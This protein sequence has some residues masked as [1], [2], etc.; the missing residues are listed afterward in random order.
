MGT[1]PFSYKVKRSN[2]RTVGIRIDKEGSVTVRAPKNVSSDDI[3]KF[4]LEKKGW[5]L[6]KVKLMRKRSSE[7][8]ERTFNQGDKLPYLGDV[9]KISVTDNE[10]LIEKYKLSRLNP[11]TLEDDFYVLKGDFDRKDAFIK[12]YKDEAREIFNSRIKELAEDYN[13]KYKKVKLSNAKTRWGSCSSKGNLNINW[14]IIFAPFE[15]VNYLLAHEVAH[16]KHHNHSK[17][18]WSLVEKYDSNYKMHRKW[19]KENGH[20]LVI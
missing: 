16:L 18:F 19:L 7:V 11:V 14:R 17:D 1:I 5:V 13:L 15:I 4:L 10:K 12:W 9:Y 6:D 20:K 8:P 2:R 3:E